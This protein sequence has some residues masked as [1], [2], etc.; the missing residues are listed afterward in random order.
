M[1]YQSAELTLEQQFSLRSFEA[2]VAHM[3]RE[4]AQHFLVELYQSMMIRESMYK[5]MLKHQWLG[6]DPVIRLRDDCE[7]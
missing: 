3:S 4:Q 6:P 7:G 2:Q 5:H 1:D